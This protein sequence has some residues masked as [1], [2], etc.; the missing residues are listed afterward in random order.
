MG[1]SSR[2]AGTAWG[3]SPWRGASRG[4]FITSFTSSACETGILSY[5]FNLG[6]YP[7]TPSLENKSS[8]SLVHS[9]IPH[10]TAETRAHSEL[11]HS[12]QAPLGLT[13]LAWFP[14]GADGAQ[15]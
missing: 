6:N 12:E 10:P 1:G 8:P 3:A 14:G 7:V 5:Q 2:A 13:E 11:A 4:V 9:T 15:Q